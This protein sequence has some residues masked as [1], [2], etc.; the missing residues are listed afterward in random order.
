MTTQS[1]SRP[2]VSVEAV[3]NTDREL[4]REL[5][6]DYYCPSIH[7][8]SD[9]RIGIN[10]GG[11]VHV[12]PLAGWHA[13]AKLA[14]A[15][16]ALEKL[17]EKWARDNESIDQGASEA[18][19]SCAAETRARLLPAQSPPADPLE[20]KV[21]TLTANLNYL[22]HHCEI[23]IRRFELFHQGR[24]PMTLGASPATGAYELRSAVNKVLGEK[25][26]HRDQPASGGAE[27]GGERVP[28]I[29]RCR[30]E[31]NACATDTDRIVELIELLVENEGASVEIMCPNPDGPPYRAIEVSDDWTG[32]QPQRFSGESLGACLEAALKAS[33]AKEGRDK[34]AAMYANLAEPGVAH[35]PAPAEQHELP[36][37]PGILWKRADGWFALPHPQAIV[38]LSGDVCAVGITAE[39]I[40]WIGV[41]AELPRGGWVK[42]SA[43]REEGS[44]HDQVCRIQE[45]AQKHGHKGFFDATPWWMW[46]DQQLAESNREEAMRKELEEA[47]KKTNRMLCRTID[48]F[49]VDA[50]VAIAGAVCTPEKGYLEDG[51]LRQLL[52]DIKTLRKQHD[53]A[54]AKLTALEAE[55]SARAEVIVGGEGV[56]L[57]GGEWAVF[58]EQND[59]RVKVRWSWDCTIGTDCKTRNVIEGKVAIRLPSTPP[60]APSEQEQGERGKRAIDEFWPT[61]Q[62]FFEYARAIIEDVMRGKP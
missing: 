59:P 60:S 48:E 41:I 31:V 5:E 47:K 29:G 13:L 38:P 18:F 45:I 14:A 49:M 9:G 12:M 15:V 30:V 7:V 39:G 24:V 10:V 50:L 51:G 20:Q 55:L 36:N 25:D 53:A 28:L 35:P 42:A 33:E 17:F 4:W 16:E 23:A 11:T 34:L 32:W 37:E 46:I 6:R 52:A 22:L 56:V 27:P 19:A 43:E 57:P 58:R 61:R 8:T 2:S 40:R 21:Q 54:E 44:F 1:S 3:E 62:E 26:S